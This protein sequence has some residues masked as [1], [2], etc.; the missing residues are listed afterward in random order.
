MVLSPEF[1]LRV[2]SADKEEERREWRA[3]EE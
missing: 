1:Y 3:D 2:R